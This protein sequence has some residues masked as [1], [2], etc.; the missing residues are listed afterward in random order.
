MPDEKPHDAWPRYATIEIMALFFFLA[1]I[2]R[3]FWV[4]ERSVVQKTK[5][6]KRATAIVPCVIILVLKQIPGTRS[7][8]IALCRTDRSFH[9][10]QWRSS[11]GQKVGLRNDWLFQKMQYRTV[12]GCMCDFTPFFLKKTTV[13]P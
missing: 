3:R 6:Q 4:K 13:K 12:E 2:F 9:T 10:Q 8:L 1:Y 5:K 11:T 7:M